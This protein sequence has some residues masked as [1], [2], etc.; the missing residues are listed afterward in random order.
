VVAGHGTGGWIMKA[1]LAG[2]PEWS[3]SYI[4]LGYSDADAGGSI[5]QTRD[6]GYIVAGTAEP[7][8]RGI[9]Q[10]WLLKLDEVGNVQWSRTYT[11]PAGEEAFF[12]A[13]QTFDGGYVAVGNTASFGYPPGHLSNG[14][15]V[16]LDRAGNVVWQE[17][18]G[19]EDVSS[20]DQTNDGGFVLSGT[21]GVD[22]AAEAWV[23]KLSPEGSVVWQKGYALSPYYNRAYFVQQTHDGGYA[24][25]VAAGFLFPD[26]L[27][28]KLDNEGDIVWQ[29]TYG[30]GWSTTPAWIGETSDEGFMVVG[31]FTRA[32]SMGTDGPWVLRLDENGNK[33]W[34]RLY[35][36]FL[37]SFFQAQ[38]SKGGGLV[39]VG[40]RG[41][42]PWV[43]KLDDEGGIQGCP[44]GVPTNA[45]LT[46]AHSTTTGA[47][48]TAAVM[49]NA[50]VAQTGVAVASVSPT[51]QT[52]C[53]GSMDRHSEPSWQN[54]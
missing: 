1:N 7:M 41:G 30:G 18:F 25:A 15:V 14:W 3:R 47:V 44:F 42:A 40:D 45:T 50:I 23:L 33:V 17:A 34:D 12:Q 36:G 51:V 39:V 21:V 32:P 31:T 11:G 29:K 22:G 6:G 46:D 8:G 52:Q 26:A 28:L 20:I 24:V 54:S 10:A 4:P 2:N 53:I 48:V 13:Q 5:Q 37:D 38:V 9:V 49:T 19:G 16:K 27:I 35:G 43:L